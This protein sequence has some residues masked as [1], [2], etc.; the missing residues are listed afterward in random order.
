[1]KPQDDTSPD[2]GQSRSTVGLGAIVGLKRYL[3]YWKMKDDT[4]LTHE[5]Q[6][7]ERM[8]EKATEP[9]VKDARWQAIVDATQCLPGHPNG[10]EGPCFCSD[11]KPDWADA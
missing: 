3:T 9:E 10:Y 1:M 5:L 4:N 11:C 7:Y 6:C 8:W 2:E